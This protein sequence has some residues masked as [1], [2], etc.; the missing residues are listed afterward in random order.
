MSQ[1]TDLTKEKNFFRNSCDRVSNSRFFEL[2]L[3][4][5]GAFSAPPFNHLFLL[6]LPL[7]KLKKLIRLDAVDRTAPQRPIFPA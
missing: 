2:G 6:F 3:I 1:A 4:F 7:P 5:M